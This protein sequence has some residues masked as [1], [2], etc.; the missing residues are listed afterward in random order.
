VR[1]GIRALEVARARLL[2]RGAPGDRIYSPRRA[3]IDGHSCMHVEVNHALGSKT[4]L[5]HK[6]GDGKFKGLE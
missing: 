3:A 1:A 6:K 5:Q 4:R 2:L